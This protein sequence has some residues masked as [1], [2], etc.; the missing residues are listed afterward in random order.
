MA[1]LLPSHLATTLYDGGVD[2]YQ[3]DGSPILLSASDRAEQ[4]P[5]VRA[6]LT[7]PGGVLV[8]HAMLY[9]GMEAP[10]VILITRKMNEDGMRSHLTRAVAQLV[11]ITNSGKVKEEEV[12]ENFD[13]TRV[14]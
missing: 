1:G 3:Y 13:I 7:G 14:Q 6:W 8:T 11:V 4:R 9:R 12:G 10:T 2:C 5:G